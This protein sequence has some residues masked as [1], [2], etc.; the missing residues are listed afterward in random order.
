MTTS[1]GPGFWRIWATQTLSIIGSTVSGIGVAVH[2]YVT[3]GDA[4]WLGYL[5]AVAAAP[6][7]RFSCRRS[8]AASTVCRAAQR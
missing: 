5:T 2:V 4:R 6:R 1:L 8:C 7:Q 3:T